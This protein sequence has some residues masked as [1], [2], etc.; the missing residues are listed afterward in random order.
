VSIASTLDQES[1]LLRFVQVINIGV[2]RNNGAE[3]SN[4]IR[5]SHADLSHE[6]WSDMIGK[7]LVGMGDYLGSGPKKLHNHVS[8]KMRHCEDCKFLF[9]IDNHFEGQRSC[10]LICGGPCHLLSRGNQSLS[11]DSLICICALCQTQFCCFQNSRRLSGVGDGP[12]IN[13]SKSWW[14]T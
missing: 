10:V 8:M 14:V 3:S 7:P 6:Q 5:G 1:Q 11:R 12:R 4:K 2:V 9:G 13:H